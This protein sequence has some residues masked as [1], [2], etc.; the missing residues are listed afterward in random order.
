MRPV[1]ELHR[2]V[3][4]EHALFC[5]GV[6]QGRSEGFWDGWQAGRAAL[7]QEQLQARP[8]L[9]DLRE[10][11]TR[12]EDHHAREHM[13]AWRRSVGARALRRSLAELEDQGVKA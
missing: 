5:A 2:T 6:R 9:S 7:I 4:Q 3:E 12:A 1:N 8:K 13:S 11:L 10:N